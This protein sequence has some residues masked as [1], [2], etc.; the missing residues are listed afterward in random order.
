MKK[1][2]VNG[3][4]AKKGKNFLKATRRRAMGIPESRFWPAERN[5]SFLRPGKLPRAPANHGQK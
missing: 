4:A 2:T 5:L 1:I 3:E